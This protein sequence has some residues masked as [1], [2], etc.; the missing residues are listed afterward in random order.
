MFQRTKSQT[1]GLTFGL[2]FRQNL[3]LGL[4]GFFQYLQCKIFGLLILRK[5]ENGVHPSPR[6]RMLLEFVQYVAGMFLLKDKNQSFIRLWGHNAIF[7][8]FTY[9][10]AVSRVHQIDDRVE[11]G[12]VK[13]VIKIQ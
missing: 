6:V 4:D 9:R 2:I 10:I 5:L 11:Q 12:Y 8:L 13:F 1:D 7:L 3:P